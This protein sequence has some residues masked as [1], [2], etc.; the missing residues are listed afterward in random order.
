M[1]KPFID[2]SFVIVTILSIVGLYFA[3]SNRKRVSFLFTLLAIIAAILSYVHFFENIDVLPP[4]INIATLISVVLVIY[5]YKILKNIRL[6]TAWL[7]GIHILRIPVEIIL[8]Q[9]S[10][11][12]LIPEIMTFAGW[13]WDILSGLSAIIILGLFLNNQLN[14]KLFILWNIASIVL[15]VIIVITALLSAPSPI[16]Q[17]AFNQP[18]IAVLQFPYALLPC[19]I[20]P[21]VFLSHFLMLRQLYTINSLNTVQDS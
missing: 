6:N 9:L 10:A 7:I 1:L 11:L 5:S 8:F 12:K 3:T 20:V 21:I 2:V 4:R 13:N 15:L 17:F 16:Q 14:R 19:V 18:N